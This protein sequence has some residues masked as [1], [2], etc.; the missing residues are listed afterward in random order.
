MGGSAKQGCSGV[1][2]ARSWEA[3]RNRD[4]VEWRKRGQSELGYFG[5]TKCS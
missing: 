2:G 1:E 5:K 3:V 4:V